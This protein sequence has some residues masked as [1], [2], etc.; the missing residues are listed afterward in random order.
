MVD[1]PLTTY[2]NTLTHR[3][4]IT[5]Y[6]SLID[7]S[8]TVVI[9]TL[10]GFNG[11][12]SKVRLQNW[13]S[14][15]VEWLEDTLNPLNDQLNGSITSSATS[16]TVDDA[17]V[18]E[19]GMVILIDA[20]YIWVSAVNTS[21]NVLTV[22]RHFGGTQA[23]HSDNAPVYIK[24]MARLEGA[25]SD[26][27]AVTARTAPYNYTGIFHQEVS[28][29]RS[30]RR[31]SQYGISDE[32]EYQI[33]KAVPS[34]ARLVNLG[35]YH[36]QRKAGSASTPRAFGGYKTFIVSNTVSAGGAV[37]KA[38]FQE[39][40]RKAYKA[41]GAGEWNAYCSPENAQVITNFYDNTSYLRVTPEQEQVGMVIKRILTP[42]GIANIIV[43]RF[44]PSD[45][46]PLIDPTR[47]GFLE[48]E[49]FFWRELG[50]KGDKDTTE[51]VGEF[52]FV[53]ANE[54]AHARITGIS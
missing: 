7:P 13:P 1:S 52:T 25:D 10:G 6:I 27:V 23:S 3:R 22:V 2:G 33:N 12:A 8:D 36:G 14:T 28:V 45:E 54:K 30:K 16:I 37:T 41:G 18:F 11:A 20:E 19:P 4:A 51:V 39:A 43:D 9:E 31:I 48:Y 35:F 29:S 15:K 21:T 32:M 47:A 46:I 5:D 49:P 24:T 34:L 53:L 40:I 17:S 44:A 38:K 26:S 42:F 50:V